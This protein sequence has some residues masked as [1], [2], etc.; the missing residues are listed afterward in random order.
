M[1]VREV[2]VSDCIEPTRSGNIA[3]VEEQAVPAA[4]AAGQ[5]RFRIHGDVVALVGTNARTRVGRAVA[6]STTTATTTTTSAPTTSSS[7]TGSATDCVG[8]RWAVRRSCY[9]VM[10]DAR[11][12]DDLRIL[13]CC[14]R[15]LDDLDAETR[16]V[17]IVALAAGLFRL[18]DRRVRRRLQAAGQLLR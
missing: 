5:A 6:G 2:R 12:T 3:N 9:Q 13:R 16:G 11:G 1:P 17:G 7:C 15:Y 8:W 10:E 14:E 18:A 4:R